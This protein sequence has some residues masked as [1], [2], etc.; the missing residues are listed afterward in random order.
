MKTVK[1]YPVLDVIALSIAIVEDRGFVSKKDAAASGGT[2]ASTCS[3]VQ[4]ALENNPADELS[5]MNQPF[6][7][8]AGETIEWAKENLRGEFGFTVKEM[9]NKVEVT[10]PQ[11]AFLVTLPNQQ[12]IALQ[13]EIAK[14]EIAD[15]VAVSQWFGKVSKR[16]EFFVKLTDKKYIQTYDSYIYNVVTREGN[17]GSFF[18]R[19]SFEL[20]IGDCF[21]M[22][23][24]PK[25]HCISNYHGGKETQF[26]RV[27]IKEIVGT[28]EKI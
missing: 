10:L 21:I 24:T 23:A 13:R 14:S 18:S 28:K 19:N 5:E 17:I 22:K 3:L 20:N 2:L 7:T 6:Y 27:V 1:K 12:K 15:K 4:T 11:V 8:R 16:D 9:L 26:N 25:R